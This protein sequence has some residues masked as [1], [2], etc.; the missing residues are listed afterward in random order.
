MCRE[1]TSLNLA[2]LRGVT[3][4]NQYVVIKYLGKGANGRVFLCL[5]MCDNRLYAVK[6]PTPNLTIN[7]P[8]SS[9][10]MNSLAI[11]CLRLPCLAYAQRLDDW[12]IV[13][14]SSGFKAWPQSASFTLC[15][16]RHKKRWGA[17][18]SVLSATLMH[19]CADREEGGHGERSRPQEA[20]P[21]DRP[22]ARG[23]HHAHAAPQEHRGPAGACQA[24][25]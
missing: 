19:S 9:Y 20:Q 4:V 3:F 23:C 8:A 16:M 18:V 22:T 7:I 10:C 5:D 21:A 1:T 15:M 6:V 12:G 11:P 14:C 2:K 25:S 24:W 17:A 13:V